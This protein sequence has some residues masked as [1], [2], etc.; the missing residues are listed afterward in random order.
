MASRKDERIEAF[1]A[2]YLPKLIESYQPS[3][4][5]VF[6]SRARGTQLKESDLDL[7]VV[8]RLFEGIP[9]IERAHRV[10]WTLRTPFPVELLCYT[11]EEFEQKKTEIGL[12]RIASEE[13]IDLLTDQRPSAEAPAR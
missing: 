10:L 4:V 5:L 11:P 12:V 1:R 6:G 8:S 13:G 7:M 3:E 2:R 9:F